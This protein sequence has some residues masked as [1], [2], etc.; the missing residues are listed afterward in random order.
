MT[1][2]IIRCAWCLRDLGTKDGQGQTGTTHSICAE[3]KAAFI[4]G[5]E[6]PTET[7]QEAA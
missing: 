1:T 4:E 3:C 7:E 5:V 6:G 2:L